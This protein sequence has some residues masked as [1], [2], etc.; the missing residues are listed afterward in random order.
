MIPA[1]RELIAA[2]RDLIE[3]CKD[4]EEGFRHAAQHVRS[5]LRS[6]LLNTYSL[7]A[8]RFADELKAELRRLGGNPEAADIYSG[9]ASPGWLTITGKQI[10]EDE[11]AILAECECGV[12]AAEK[13]YT[14]ALENG[15]PDKMRS[16]VERQH[17]ELKQISTRI[18][19]WAGHHRFGIRPP[20]REREVPLSGSDQR[21]D[22][23]PAAGDRGG[24]NTR[25]E[26]TTPA[27][28]APPG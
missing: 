11:A 22:R 1:N 21:D 15:L 7:A 17:A 12:D 13:S 2:L 4:S 25:R 23:L 19:G 16:L 6:A 26:P 24:G 14:A 20:R 18:H 27:R 8:A 10:E 28:P 3:T 5:N 9:L